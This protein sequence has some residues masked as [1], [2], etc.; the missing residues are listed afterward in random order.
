MIGSRIKEICRYL[1]INESSQ[2][3]AF[4]EKMGFNQQNISNY[5]NDENAPRKDFYEAVEKAV[6]EINVEWLKTGKGEM[7]NEKAKALKFVE[8]EPDLNVVISVLVEDDKFF[9]EEN[10]FLRDQIKFLQTLIPN[11]QPTLQHAR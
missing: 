2:Q 4:A 1:G 6:P 7:L 11:P 9:K 5:I 3:T 8:K 10:K